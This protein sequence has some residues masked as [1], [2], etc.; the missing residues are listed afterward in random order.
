MSLF[1][2]GNWAVFG[3]NT[4][5]LDG[6][7]KNL[8]VKLQMVR[9]S[10]LVAATSIKLNG[11]PTA[12]IN[13]FGSPRL[14]EEMQD[15]GEAARLVSM[16]KGIEEME[17]VPVDFGSIG[18]LI[19]EKGT[20]SLGNKAYGFW[21]AFNDPKDVTDPASKKEAIA[22]STIGV[23]FKFLNK[24]DKEMVEEK[25]TSS[26]VMARKQVPVIADFQHG[27]VYAET[28]NKND[29]QAIR[30][31]LESLGA[32]TFSL[33]W[34][35]D[36]ASWTSNFLT[37]VHTDTRFSSE[38]K[39]RAEEL[40]RF[41]S[42]EVEK[43]A[44]KEMEKIVSSF[45]AFT[46]VDSGLVV[47]LGCPSLVRMYPPSDPVGVASP[48]V[49][50][51]LLN[52]TN[53]SEIAGASVTF[54][55]PITRKVKGGGEKVVN[56]PVLSLD[57]NENVNCFDAGAA[58]LRGLELPQFKR[59]IKTALKAQGKMEIKDYWSLW[60]NGMHDAV[61][62]FVDNVT[63]VLGINKGCGLMPYEPETESSEETI[64]IKEA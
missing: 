36:S 23:P 17:T 30:D 29:I 57:I 3:V 8:G 25:V 21:M 48:S 1:G 11:E 26:A 6:F 58:L 51:S 18:K 42:T 64:E 44:D 16:L 63:D 24:K 47:A 19:P 2:R 33:L 54:L 55:E 34:N 52:M 40:S 7:E 61:L 59:T 50:F 10:Q 5:S 22:Y 37:Q 27:R 31:T 28:T 46:P 32:K 62:I 35:F 41:R 13:P 56:K 45:F 53:S 20:L 4:D 60:L 38:M 9:V 39:S 15:G 12:G 49:A 43:L 14:D